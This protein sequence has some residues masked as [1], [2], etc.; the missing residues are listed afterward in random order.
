MS[1]LADQLVREVRRVIE[2]EGVSGLL[3]DYL[4]REDLPLLGWSGSASHVASVGRALDRVVLG[5]V[6]YL[7]VRA[8]GGEPIAKC[9]IDYAKTAGAG[10]IYQAATASGLQSLGIGARLI[11]VA[12]ER[13]RRRSVRIAELGVEDDNPRARSL[14]ERLGYQEVRRERASWNRQDASGNLVLY[15]TELAV[16]RKTV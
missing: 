14:Y 11:A 16:L 7:A 1:V 12:E 4:T 3:I 2:T 6:E 13:I 15:E 8:P 9:G 5:E 10:W